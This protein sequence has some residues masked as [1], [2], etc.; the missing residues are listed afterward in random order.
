MTMEHRKH[1]WTNK[2]LS[3]KKDTNFDNISEEQIAAVED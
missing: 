2:T 3:S 1:K